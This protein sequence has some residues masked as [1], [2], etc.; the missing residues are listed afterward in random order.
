[1]PYSTHK[2]RPSSGRRSPSGGSARKTSS[3][4]S[5]RSSANH[6]TSKG[7]SAKFK[8]STN[9][10]GG[11]ARGTSPSGSYHSSSR[12]SSGGASS[13][14]GSA[15]RSSSKSP[16]PKFKRSTIASRDSRRG[17]FSSSKRGSGRGGHHGEKIAV[18][19]FINRAPKERNTAPAP[20]ITHTFSNFGFEK[21]LSN[22][23]AKRGHTTP[24]P[25]QDQTIPH[26]LNDLDVL[27][28]ANTGTGKTAAFLLPLI[29]RVLKD[30]NHST[31]ILAPTRELA[32]QIND[33]LRSFTNGMNIHSTVCV[34]G[35][36][37]HP[38]IRSLKRRN[39]FVIG[40]PGRIIDL[41]KTKALFLDK[42][43]TIVLDEADRMLDMGFINDMKYVISHMPKERNTLF[44]SAT[45][46]KE[47]EGL[48]QDFL[49][50]P[51][52]IS[53]VIGRTSKNIAQDVVYIKGRDKVEVLIELLKKE[54]LHKVLVFA[55]TK[56]GVDKLCGKLKHAGISADS[57]HGNKSFA[58]RIRALTNFKQNRVD[59]LI[60]TDVAA[61]GIDVREISHVINFDLPATYDDYVHRIGRTGRGE[62]EGQA[63]TFVD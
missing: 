33:E 60:A 1:M 54:D 25:I 21:A 31:I 63:L 62:H 36:P 10:S 9:T 41:M 59:V 52:V 43:N 20:T 26:I 15:N 14:R 45:M 49:K 17:G 29:N 37:I 6:G 38:Q 8:R 48:M 39:H 27:G 46:S 57:I 11:S 56:H 19:R 12:N 42:M 32:T 23:I 18:D 3:N 5:S 2:A 51:V 55:R 16:A 24:T 13:Y 7:P 53:V 22:A 47:V 4:G 61:R 35:A 34:G 28:L 40:T 30:N 44:F 50:S 58:Q